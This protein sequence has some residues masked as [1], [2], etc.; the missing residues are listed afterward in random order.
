MTP[1]SIL[2]PLQRNVLEAFFDTA[3]GSRFFLTGGT[4]LAEYYLRHRYSE[5]LDFFT[6]DDGAIPLVRME[7]PALGPTLSATVESVL[8]S[9][10]FQRFL[11][12]RPGEAP[13]QVDL[14]RDV[15]IQFGQ[16]QRHGTVIVDAIENIAVNKVSAIFGRTTSKDFVD[17][18]FL[19]EAGY[20]LRTLIERAKEKDGGLTEFWL[21]GMLRQAAT[22]QELPAMIKPLSLTT[23]KEFYA[24][25]AADLMRA[26]KPPR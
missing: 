4:A 9:A 25:L 14:V 21:A 12:T 10:T 23:I 2:T 5:D 19:L 1:A 3:T 26:A 22:L 13:L 8:S 24:Q 18:Y 15:D 20:D 7:M 17:L 6:T 16:H 11:V